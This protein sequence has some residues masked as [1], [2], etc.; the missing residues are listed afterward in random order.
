[1]KDVQ[2]QVEG[3]L[4]DIAGKEPLVSLS[5]DD[6]DGDKEPQAKAPS[7]DATVL[8]LAQEELVAEI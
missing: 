5:D 4:D 7:K 3:Y 1:M 6:E 8:V 2:E